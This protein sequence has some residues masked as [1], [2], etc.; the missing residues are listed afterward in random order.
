MSIFLALT[1][2]G[3]VTGGLY[4]LTSSGLVVTY[5]VS[6]VFN[7][8]HGAIGMVAAFLC[9]QLVV[10]AHVPIA[11]AMVLVVFVVAP[12][13]GGLVER[14]VMRRLRGAPSEVSLVVTIGLMLTLLG[15]AQTVW[16]ASEPRV[17]P[18]LFFGDSVGILG[19]NVTYEQILIVVVVIAVAIGLRVFLYNTGPGIAMRAVVDDGDLAACAGISPVRYSQLGWALGAMLAAAAG[20]LIA[21]LT[22]LDATG[23][24][25]VVVE[26]YAAAVLG[27][28]RNLPL[29]FVGG[30][31]LGLALT[32]GTG[33]LPL[34]EVLNTVQ[35]AIPVI[36]LFA[37]LLL[38]PEQ[39]FRSAR[40]QIS[41]LRVPRVP[42]RNEVVAAGILF[43]GAIWLLTEVL[44][45]SGLVV[46]GHALAYALIALSL[47]PLVGYGGQTSLCQL[48]FAG[49]GAFI[50]GHVADGG[51]VLALAAA[52][53]V[54]AVAGAIV[55]LPALRLRGLYL[56]LATLAFAETMDTVFFGNP[57][58][59]PENGLLL[60]RF[61]LPGIS[62]QGD[63]PFVLMTAVVFVVVAFAVLAL[64]RSF[65]GRRIIAMAESPTACASLGLNRTWTRFGLF[66]LSAGIAGL[67]GAIYGEQQHIVGANDFA[68]LNSLLMLLLITLGGVRC[69]SGAAIAAFA[70]AIFPVIE[71]HV[72][73]LSQIAYLF[74]GLAAVSLGQKPDG[75]MGDL[76]Q[77]RTKLIGSRIGI[78]LAQWRSSFGAGSPL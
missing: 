73:W 68:Y 77:A 46:T 70:L 63:R 62:L 64:R 35:P 42:G 26:G 69:V 45:A 50:A 54:T 12:L 20:I 75:I 52:V 24:T 40:L 31:V 22:T 8:A 37:A 9:W 74:T 78:R 10:P 6:G 53:G 25:L 51:S 17:A 72:S 56:A 34:G 29:T 32:Y 58:A 1:V 15:L 39:A 5:T 7:F 19:I 11:L 65:M 44:S 38:L 4:A 13:F 23:L 57:D 16:P 30:L 47:V 41:L 59:F 76:A 27:R 71:V 43:V 28:L 49:I 2:V 61:N 48:T 21:P 66:A 14:I 36:F 33:Y 18:Q 3:I 60:R 55:A 67:G